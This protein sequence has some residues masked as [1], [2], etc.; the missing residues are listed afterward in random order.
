MA[1][2]LY[3][4]KYEEVVGNSIVFSWH[5]DENTLQYSTVQDLWLSHPN[6]CG[7][8]LP[9]F[10]WG[11]VTQMRGK[12]ALDDHMTTAWQAKDH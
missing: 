5:V 7:I 12:D 3:L 2:F 9:V 4:W 10:Q 1:Y 6:A 8:S 11:D